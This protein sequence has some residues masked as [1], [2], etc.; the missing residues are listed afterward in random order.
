MK[1]NPR[2]RGLTR[3]LALVLGL[4]MLASVPA[5]AAPGDVTISAAN[6]P[7]AVFR[8]YVSETFD[9]NG[10]GTL[11]AAE[12]ASATEI[13]CSDRK[14]A[15]L[16]GVEYLTSLKVLWCFINQ[17]TELDVSRN[18]SLEKLFCGGNFFET[19]D[20]SKNT[21]LKILQIDFSQIK[22]IDLSK[23]TQ[24]TGF[25]CN[26]GQLTE[27]DV[28]HNPALEI[29][30]CNYS[31][32]TEL[33]VSHNPAL[34]ELSCKTNQLTE[35]DVTQNPAL[36]TLK[37]SGSITFLDLSGNAAL[38]ELDCTGEL[39]TLD[40]R[41]CPALQYAVE[42][43]TYSNQYHQD[44]YTANYNGQDVTCAVKDDVRL[45]TGRVPINAANFPAAEFRSYVRTNF[46]TNN[47]GYL[48]LAEC[49]AP[50]ELRL[51]NAGLTSLAGVEYFPN[52]TYL[53]CSGNALTELDL[54]GNPK[55]KTLFCENN[56]LTALDLRSCHVLEK[57][58]CYN[59]DLS[60]LDLTRSPRLLDAVLD[61]YYLEHSTGGDQYALD[62]N[63]L[64]ADET[65]ALL[66]GNDGLP[67]SHRYFPDD[68]FRAW[69][70]ERHDSDGDRFFSDDE[71]AF[72]TSISCQNMD[73]AGLSGLEH[74]PELL[75]LE[76]SGNA[77][78]ELDLRGNPKLGVLFC[79]NNE[80][81]E[82]QLG[83]KPDLGMLWCYNNALS[84]LD[85]SGCPE[86]LHAV[87]HG[88]V[89]DHGTYVSYSSPRGTAYIDKA[90]GI[91]S[92]AVLV[93]DVNGDGSVTNADAALLKR[94]IAGWSVSIDRNAADL[95]R[96]GSVTNADAALLNRYIAGWES[97]DSYIIQVPATP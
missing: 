9:T 32:L 83:S 74:F 16:Q 60:A 4:L 44:T 22:T 69:L 54:R 27:L 82:L 23:N 79:E 80:I 59:D 26:Y 85:L 2:L 20:V 75:E 65:T 3:A 50:T 71:R 61:G 35:L 37:C 55:L 24:L 13:L 38:T 19:L 73:I 34:R 78:T 30:L 63:I 48:S 84:A 87:E 29:L 51:L 56:G 6:F 53:D 42:N 70:R 25:S 31:Q 21:A 77:I 43:G 15:S 86:I 5:F 17:L 91:T 11:S 33:D 97:Y 7:D 93:G 57:L 66:L 76:C 41:G 39:L 90:T 45:V 64:L 88:S 1:G 89:T 28:S 12:I 46:D 40:L 49:Q 96:D 52:L 36:E 14:I 47:D 67:I 92:A 62:G 68:N 58:F 10:D 18:T 72:V 95:N 94:Y 81:A 8:Q